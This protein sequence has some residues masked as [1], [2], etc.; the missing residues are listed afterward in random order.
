[1]KYDNRYT[2]HIPMKFQLTQATF[3][4]VMTLIMLGAQF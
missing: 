1:M 2:V 3:V 4:V